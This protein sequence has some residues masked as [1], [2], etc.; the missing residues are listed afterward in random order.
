MKSSFNT[1]LEAATGQEDAG[2]AAAV[3]AVVA[4]AANLIHGTGQTGGSCPGRG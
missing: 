2:A 1:Y 4:V 3:A